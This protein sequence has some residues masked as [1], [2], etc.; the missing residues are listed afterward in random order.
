MRL[1]DVLFTQGFGTRRECQAL[2]CGG[3]VE[4]QGQVLR[5]PEQEIDPEGKSFSVSGHAWPYF[6][7][8]L[9]A[10]NKP[11]MYECSQKPSFHPSVM[12]L[13]PAP[14]RTRGMQPIGRLDVDATG[15][16]LFTDDGALIHRL[17]HPKKHVEKTYEVQCN[18][19]V[20]RQQIEKLL[21]G[22]LLQGE[23]M[24]C[25]AVRCELLGERQLRLTITS[26]KYHQVKRMVAAVGNHVDGLHRISIGR[27]T[28]PE[29]LE[30]GQWVWLDAIQG[31]FAKQEG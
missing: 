13:L 19:L 31:L 23:K 1:E 22:V 2:I 15:L 25:K 29:D 11:A 7:R 17:T 6:A 24:P 14:L 27:Y 4:F 16:L 10:M 26:G 18:R 3:E 8:A 21:E 30:P 12:R 5:D 9:I 28:L 20:T